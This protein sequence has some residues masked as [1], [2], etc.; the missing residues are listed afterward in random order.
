VTARI[1]RI[2]VVGAGFAGLELLLALRELAGDRVHMTLV[3]P[4]PEFVVRPQLIAERFGLDVARRL[5][6]RRIAADADCELVTASV[7]SVDPARRVV[8]LRA[9]GTLPY[10]TLVL[11]PG[12]RTLPAFDGVIT[13]DAEGTAQLKALHDEIRA[14]DVKSL[15]F[16]A[17]VS[18]GW[19]LPLY[20]AALIAANGRDPVRV[21]LITPEARPLQRFGA[22][23]SAAVAHALRAADIDFIGSQRADVVGGSVRLRGHT[24]GAVS[25]DRIVALPLVRGRRIPGVPASEVF[26]LIPVDRY[27]R[28][29]GLPGVYAAGD[30]TD[31]PI[32]QG[33]MA[34]DQADAIAATIAAHHGAPVPFEPILGATLLTGNGAPLRLGAANGRFGRAKLPGRYLA[35]Y[36]LSHVDDPRP[37]A[38]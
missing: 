11:A 21:S 24:R 25:A 36:M 2:V 5:P 28:V 16:V 13:L 20:E 9:G 23:A 32:K 35:P 30:A 1:P 37:V 3:A 22:A 6:L 27:A 38:A 14:G 26:G 29:A 10:D 15:A 33:A 12:A 4:E 18:T 8:T 7:A 31:S 34:C 17:P 19:L